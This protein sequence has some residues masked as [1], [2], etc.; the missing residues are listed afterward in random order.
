MWQQ[1]VEPNTSIT[2]P[3]G[4]C[5]GLVQRVY[6]APG[7]HNTAWQ[8]WQATEDKH[9]D[10]ELPPVSVP[11]WFD[12]W[13]TY[14]GVYGQF[15]HVVAWIPGRG[16]LSSPAN[17]VGQ[18]WVATIEQVERRYNSKY[19]GWTTDINTVKVAEY[20]KEDEN[21]AQG[22]FYRNPRGGIVWQEKPNTVLIPLDIVTW[23]AYAEQGNKFI[24]ISQ[25]D[26]DNLIK[27]FGTAP[28]PPAN[29][30]GTVNVPDFKITMTG[31][32]NKK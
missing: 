22:A 10:R 18:D 29:G 13:G 31:E 9:Y 15:G 30:G 11:L 16:F 7:L 27:K 32:A 1:L 25:K 28:K 8:A 3:A 4:W 6:G 12:H 20:V 24:N 5:L 17:G 14:G 26:F 19:V 2:M 23:S 21:M